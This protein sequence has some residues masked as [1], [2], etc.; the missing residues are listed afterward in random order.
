MAQTFDDGILTIYSTINAAEP[1]MKP[2]INL[3]EKSRYYYEYETLGI[4]RYYTALQAQQ[5]IEAVVCVPG[6]GDISATDICALENG[7]QYNIKMRQ[8]TLD[9]EGLRITKLSLERVNQEYA[10]QVDGDTAGAS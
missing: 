8:P 5:E 4:N 10:I 1:G 7:D 9:D 6:W 3:V 2:T